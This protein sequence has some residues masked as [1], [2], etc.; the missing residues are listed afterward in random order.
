MTGWFDGLSAWMATD[1]PALPSLLALRLGLLAS[2]LPV[3]ALACLWLVRK[4]SLRLRRIGAALPL[5]LLLGSGPWLPVH[6]LGL[7]FQ[8][9]SFSSMLWALLVCWQG[10]RSPV[11]SRAPEPATDA[12][13]G[14]SAIARGLPPLAGAVLGWLLLLDTFALL[15]MELYAWGFSP[16]ALLAMLALSL[17]PL[18]GHGWRA[19]MAHPAGW[20]WPGALLLFALT[21]LPT[22]NV[23]DAVLDPW[24]WL[25]L[26]VRWVRAAATR[27]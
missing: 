1:T 24:L 8:S 11:A 9:L 20:V 23:W 27:G 25:V 6:W 19:A 22:G 18:V 2:W 17:L 7:A 4:R 15:P 12:Q 5:L 3:L 13:L 26:N 10:V 21:R 16:L 14:L